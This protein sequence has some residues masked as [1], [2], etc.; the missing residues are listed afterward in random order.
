SPRL[1]VS[2]SETGISASWYL[3]SGPKFQ[4]RSASLPPSPLSRMS[5]CVTGN[6]LTIVILSRGNCGLSKR[7]TRYLIAMAAADLLVVISDVILT[8]MN[9][10]FYPICFLDLTPVCSLL[11]AVLC[12]AADSSVW[13]TV[14]FTFDRFLAICYQGASGSCVPERMAAM[15]IGAVWVLSCASNVPWFL[16]YD[17]YVSR[18]WTLFHWFDITLTPFLPF[19]LI[20]TLNV[21]TVRHILRKISDPETENRIKCVVL[22][23][24]ISGSFMLLWS[25]YVVFVI[26]GQVVHYYYTDYNHPVYILYHAAIMLQLS[27]SATNTCVYAV[28]QTKFREE[29]KKAVKYPFLLMIKVFKPIISLFC[30][31][32]KKLIFDT[33]PFKPRRFF[34]TFAYNRTAKIG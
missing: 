22:L 2:P 33:P 11:T 7:I 32:K 34:R 29:V 4:C 12:A 21:L 17:F 16:S 27:N 9:F 30:I 3:L 15:V 26:Y 20:L 31:E 23:F 24:A 5:L 25:T 14:A 19:S 10:L 13:L 28:T 6:L 1:F 8:R 18:N